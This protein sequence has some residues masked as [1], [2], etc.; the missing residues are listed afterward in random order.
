M[1]PVQRCPWPCRGRASERRRL[2]LENQVLRGDVEISLY[3][4]T[5]I[6]IKLN[7]WHSMMNNRYAMYRERLT[8]M[9][10]QPSMVVR[11]F[12]HNFFAAYNGAPYR[13]GLDVI[14]NLP[15]IPCGLTLLNS[16][17]WKRAV[18]SHPLGWMDRW[19]EASSSWHP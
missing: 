19:T 12:R 13:D 2:C 15:R 16:M 11:Q 7:G 1:H 8:G 6:F 4:F 3:I 5:Y 9:Q 10:H 18:V 14:Q 17:L